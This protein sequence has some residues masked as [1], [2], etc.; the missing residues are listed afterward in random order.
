[1][2][3]DFRPALADAIRFGANRRSALAVLLGVIP[4]VSAGLTPVTAAPSQRHAKR[5]AKS[6]GK[7]KKKASAG[8][9]GP[10]GSAGAQGS[11]GERGPTGPKA[12]TSALTPH[13]LPLE[14][15]ANQPPIE[16]SVNCDPG[17]IA[18]SGGFEVSG[19]GIVVWKSDRNLTNGWVVGIR[20]TTE[21]GLVT[22]RV[23]CL[24][25]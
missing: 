3:R 7:K 20:S 12:I 16:L 15:G 23:Y 6:E 14:V 10:Q 25:V 21:G 11:V 1:M 19:P 9:A 22:V 17:E 5:G 4:M 2:V 18:V 13:Q 8:P 24:P